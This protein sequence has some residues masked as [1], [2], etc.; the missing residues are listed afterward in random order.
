MNI[1]LAS[2]SPRRKLL[3][4]KMGLEFRVVPS[5]FEEYFDSKLSP[6]EL[7]CELAL[8]KA[9]AVAE[10]FPEDIVIGSDSI[11]VFKGEQIGKPK[12]VQEAMQRLRTYSGES[13]EV[14]SAVAVI[15][16]ARDYEKVDAEKTI[17]RFKT[18]PEE[19]IQ[20]Y[21]ATGDP[22]DKAGAYAIQHPLL[23]PYLGKLEGNL[24]TQI[25]FPTDLVAKFL[26]ELGINAEP[27]TISLE[28]FRTGNYHEN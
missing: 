13:H 15:C 23:L 19:L 8:G 9:R 26:N 16:K 7:T 5:D 17:I 4:E 24:D 10:R 14:V 28:M 11:V 12:D 20:K 1:I 22:M 21:V 27:H 18:M 25:G 6:S 3:M 2:T